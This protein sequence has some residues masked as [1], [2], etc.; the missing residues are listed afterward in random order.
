MV[1]EGRIYLVCYFSLAVLLDTMYPRL[2]LVQDRYWTP[3]GDKAL[4]LGVCIALNFDAVAATRT[5]VRTPY[6]NP[7]LNQSLHAFSAAD[8]K[9]ASNRRA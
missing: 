9:L 1:G 6:P 3:T 2:V 5:R 7:P 8:R 4:K